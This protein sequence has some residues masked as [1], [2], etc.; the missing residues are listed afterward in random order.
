MGNF[1]IYPTVQKDSSTFSHC[2]GHMEK[3]FYFQ[4]I[5]Y[6]IYLY[7]NFIIFLYILDGLKWM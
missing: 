6:I 5:H 7:K 3:S 2:F 4:I 1:S